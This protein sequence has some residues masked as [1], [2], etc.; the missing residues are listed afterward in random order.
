MNM[1]NVTMVYESSI[2]QRVLKLDP[3]LALTSA[4]SCMGKTTGCGFVTCHAKYGL[5][6]VHELRDRKGQ[7]RTDQ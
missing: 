4:L 2:K 6:V 5:K 3:K 7:Q 1:N